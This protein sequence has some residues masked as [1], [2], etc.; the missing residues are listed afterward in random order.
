MKI[1]DGRGKILSLAA[2]PK[3]IVSLV[4]STTESLFALGCGESVVGIT[5]FC[6]H[7][8]DRLAGLVKVGG[9]KDLVIERLE[10]LKP[11]LVIG[12]VE[13]NTTEMFQTIE[14]RFPLYAA[15]PRTVDDAIDDLR[16]M[17]RLIGAEPEAAQWA[18]RIT[19]AR[20]RLHA[21][22]RPGKDFA[23]LI[24]RNPWMAVSG[25]TFISA[26]LAEAGRV[27]ALADAPTRYPTIEP[28]QLAEIGA[29]LLS[30]E[31]FPFQDKHREE[32]AD[33]AGIPT[34]RISLVDGELCSWHGVRMA[35]AFDWLAAVAPGW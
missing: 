22:V 4:P 26:M 15:F 12:N 5:R 21:A 6:V 9:T 31:P 30:S 23:Y 7:P 32:L 11:D 8:A 1:T 16:T 10:A 29:I 17:G 35:A 14:D 34:S 27:N 13:E 28:A 19:A 20:Q 25:D 2:P 3:R 33:L 24:W 18:D